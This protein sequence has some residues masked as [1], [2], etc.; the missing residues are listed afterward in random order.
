MENDNKFTSSYLP[1]H[2][3]HMHVC[4]LI[5][6]KYTNEMQI[7]NTDKKSLRKRVTSCKTTT[8]R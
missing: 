6:L 7:L 8:V 2:A 5:D 3:I 1:L 4:T